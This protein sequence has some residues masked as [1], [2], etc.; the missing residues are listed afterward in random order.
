L[1]RCSRRSLALPLQSTLN[2]FVLK[3]TIFTKR[4]KKK[5]EFHST[6]VNELYHPKNVLFLQFLNAEQDFSYVSPDL[7]MF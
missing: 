7:Q 4:A 1:S 5:K 3:T 6:I 2:S